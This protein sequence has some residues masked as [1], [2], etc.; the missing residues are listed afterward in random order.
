MMRVETPSVAPPPATIDARELGRAST[1]ALGVVLLGWALTTDFAKVSYGFFSD[2]ATYY[3]LAHSLA[4]DFDFEYRRDDLVRVW[5]EFPSG[6]EGIFLKRGKDLAVSLTTAFPFVQVE[7]RDDPD[8]GRLY[9]GKSFAFPLAAAPF[10]ALFGTNGFLVLHALLMT[11][12][13][14]CAYAFLAAR[15]APVPALLFATAFLLVSVAPVYMVW[16]TPDFFNLALVLIAYF[17]WTYQEVAGGRLSKAGRGARWLAGVRADLIAAALL[18]V[19]TF[20]RPTHVLLVGPMLALF[21]LRRQWQRLIIAGACFSA[22]VIGM[23]ALNVAITGEWNYQGGDRRTFY[24]GQGGFPFQTDRHVFNASGPPERATDRVPIEVLASRDALLRVFPHNL[25]YF[26]F[27]RHTG[28]AAY[29]FPGLLA[30]ALFLRS[31]HDRRIWQW[32]TLA[33]GAGSAVALILYMP[34]TYSGGGGPVGNRYFLGVYP[35]F[36]FLTPPLQRIAPGVLTLGVGGLFTAQL[37]V[38]PF[39]ASFHPGEHT[40][41]GLFRWLPIE[42]SLVNDLPVNVT[43]ARARQPLGGT[44]PLLAYFLD[45]NAYNRESDAFWVRGGARADI[46]LRAPIVVEPRSDG[47]EASRALTVPRLEID[48]ETGPVPNRVTI[49]TGAQTEVVDLPASNRQRLVVRMDEGLPYKPYPEFPTN[50]IYTI[51]IESASSFI[52][53]F[54]GESRDNRLLGVFVRLVPL[55]E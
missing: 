9:Y 19:A 40:K 4:D 47:T 53:M 15:S 39:Y 43:P 10:V 30:T 22:V 51:S 2:G 23:F 37:V 36:L 1:L 32:L 26:L 31:R 34:Y 41:N 24:S 16:L 14:A 8:P 21:L 29:Y 5:R 17:F 33:A 45:D 13:F 48:L 11:A 38:N 7:S 44:P 20:S 46:L 49:R 6:P 54:A 25:A 3:S 27:G 52:P 50:Y 12:C 35:V 18:G 42:R 28:F 55:Y